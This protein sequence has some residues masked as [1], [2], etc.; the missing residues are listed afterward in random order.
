MWYV[1]ICAC[2][3]SY[4]IY[5][6]LYFH[7]GSSNAIWCPER[8]HISFSSL[9]LSRIK[10]SDSFILGL[11]AAWMDFILNQRMFWF[12]VWVGFFFYFSG[13][14][15]LQLN[16]ICNIGHEWLKTGLSSK[17]EEV[18]LSWCNI[19]H[20]GGTLWYFSHV[21]YWRDISISHSSI[22]IIMWLALPRSIS[23]ASEQFSDFPCCLNKDYNSK[24]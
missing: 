2:L 8:K 9:Y 22:F 16:R 19:N 23:Q 17:A 14:F 12:G 21:K 1:Y 6:I 10:A 20:F 5:F 15:I 18:G 13:F 3:L 24:R 4:F 7:C 11:S